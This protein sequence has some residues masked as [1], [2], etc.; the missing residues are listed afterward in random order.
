MVEQDSILDQKSTLLEDDPRD[1]G[2]LAIDGVEL[3][4]GIVM[5]GVGIDGIDSHEARTT[6]DALGSI[7]VPGGEVF[8]TT[9]DLGFGALALVGA[10]L[11]VAGF[12]RIRRS[13]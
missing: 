2:V 8:V 3:T 10:G 13:R 1:F 4:A 5:V 11:T 7:S 6:Q 9:A 12:K